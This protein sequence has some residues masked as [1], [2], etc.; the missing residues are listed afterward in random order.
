MSLKDKI[1]VALGFTY[2]DKNISP[3]CT[4]QLRDEVLAVVKEHDRRLREFFEWLEFNVTWHTI[5]SVAR[6]IKKEY[7]EK[8]KSVLE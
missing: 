5:P 3:I 7:E 1:L 6:D 2:I 8:K 4:T